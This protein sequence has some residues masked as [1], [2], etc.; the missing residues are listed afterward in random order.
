MKNLINMPGGAFPVRRRE[1]ARS[2]SR[3]F[4]IRNP[5]SYHE[6][7]IIYEMNVLQSM[8]L[9]LRVYRQFLPGVDPA[10]MK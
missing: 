8:L 10:W 9:P 3:S 7:F 1:N 2:G 5:F 4:P 6:L